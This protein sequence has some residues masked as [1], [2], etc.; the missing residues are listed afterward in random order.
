MPLSSDARLLSYL[1][2]AHVA[3]RALIEHA[4]LATG[5]HVFFAES[6]ETFTADLQRARRGSS[7]CRALVKFAAGKHEHHRREQVELLLRVDAP[8]V[9]AG[10]A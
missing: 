6:L 10:A 1:P 2:L 3:E 8:E 9:I 5:M 4:L 7:P